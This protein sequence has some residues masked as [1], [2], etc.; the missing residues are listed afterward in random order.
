VAADATG[1][2]GSTFPFSIWISSL[3]EGQFRREDRITGWMEVN[4]IVVRQYGQVK[5]MVVDFESDGA[6]GAQYTTRSR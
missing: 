2:I 4:T 6:H 1:L 3:H 5:R